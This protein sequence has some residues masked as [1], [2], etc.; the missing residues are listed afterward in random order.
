M[1]SYLHVHFSE[2]ISSLGFPSYGHITAF[3]LVLWFINEAIFEIR[4]HSIRR[5]AIACGGRLAPLAHSSLPFGLSIILDQLRIFDSGTASDMKKIFENESSKDERNQVIRTRCLGM[6]MLHVRSHLDIKHIFTNDRWDKSKDVNQAYKYILGEDSI[7]TAS[8]AATWSWHRA[9]LRPHFARKRIADFNASEEHIARVINWLEKKSEADK[10]TDFQDIASRFTLTA[11]SQ[12]LF[13]Q[14]LDMLN[15]LFLDRPVR[16]NTLNPTHLSHILEEA[17]KDAAIHSMIPLFLRKI[18][19]GLIMPN[20]TIKDIFK[21]ID[22]LVADNEKQ[23]EGKKDSGADSGTDNLVEHLQRSGCSPE[24]MSC[25]LSS[26]LLAARDTTASLLTSC[27]YELAGR[28]ELWSQLRSEVEGIPAFP[29]VSLEHLSKLKRLRAVINES[30]R[31]HTVVWRVFRQTLK[32]DVLPSGIF[33]PA[34]TDCEVYL[35]ETHRDPSVW[36]EDV[37]KFVPDRW[38]DGREIKASAF[39]PFTTGPRACM[40]QQFAITEITVALIRLLQSFTKVELVGPI[41][42]KEDYQE[43]TTGVLNFRGGLWV[44]FHKG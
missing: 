3:F 43:T 20:R 16:D 31:L 2:M 14:C 44:K 26:I 17:Q 28:D 25:E 8:M 35:S 9:L 13:G 12:H 34:G 15:D 4:Q 1:L 30:L 37:D 22:Q 39:L 42:R 6:E 19:Q 41:I 29:D 21:L 7:A 18:V 23:K 10:I 36:G 24:V 27:I 5:R 38:L 11:S 33:V 40:G 32:D